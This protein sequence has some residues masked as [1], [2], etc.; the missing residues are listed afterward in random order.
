MNGGVRERIVMIGLA[1]LLMVAA[2]VIVGQWIA[3]SKDAGGPEGATALSGD[4]SR[5]VDEQSGFRRSDIAL[6]YGRSAEG[7]SRTI[8]DFYALRAY[9]GAP[10]AVPHPIDEEMT[11]GAGLCLTCHEN[12]GYVPKWSAFTPVTPH[13]ELRNCRQCHNPQYSGSV[14]ASSQFEPL[15]PPALGASALPGSPMPMPHSIDMRENCLACHAGPGA[16]AEL[17]TTHPE[18]INCRQCHVAPEADLVWERPTPT[19]A[20]SDRSEVGDE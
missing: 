13:P 19:A 7:S 6:A 1:I 12:G 18:R 4:P 9:L 10:P 5:L 14:F 20:T 2:V 3:G 11:V 15:D 16:V 8:S 17:R